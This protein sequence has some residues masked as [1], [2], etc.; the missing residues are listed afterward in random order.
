MNST[1]VYRE[2][3]NVF[4][5]ENGYELDQEDVIQVISNSSDSFSINVETSIDTW[6]SV[7]VVNYQELLAL[8]ENTVDVP[9]Y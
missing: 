9:K 2:L 7:A 6:E 1:E 5:L 3:K 4:T 8:L